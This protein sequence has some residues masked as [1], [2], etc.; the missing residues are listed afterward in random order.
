MKTS[1][2]YAIL[3]FLTVATLAFGQNGPAVPT[4]PVPA[5]GGWRKTADVPQNPADPDFSPN[6]GQYAGQPLPSPAEPANY[7]APPQLTIRPGTFIMVRI[8]QPLSSDRNRSGDT[9]SATLLRPVVVDG[10]VVAQPGEIVGGRVAE[11][12]KAGRVEGVSRLALQLT[13]LTLVDGQPVPIQ[14]QLLSRQGPTS[15]GRDAAGVAGTTLSGAAIGAAVN[16]GVGAGVGAAAGVV[17]GAI[18]VLLTRGH[19]TV[20]YPESILTFRVDAP[21]TISTERSS[22]SFRYMDPNQYERPYDTRQRPPSGGGGPCGV[23]GCGAPP[24][25]PAYGGPAYYPYPYSYGPRVS[26][27]FGPGFYYGRGYRGYRRW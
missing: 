10:F 9:F 17:V 22:Q 16:G 15:E 3:G 8:D 14:A 19:A 20:I 27:L 26:V 18:G 4:P 13:D 5:S 11:A 24:P 21:V 23:Y 7:P 6:Q 25:P 12:Q 1:V 2:Y